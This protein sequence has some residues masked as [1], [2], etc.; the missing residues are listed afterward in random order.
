MPS[1]SF[2]I[3]CAE[4]LGQ[5]ATA[6]LVTRVDTGQLAEAA[7][8]AILEV[9]YCWCK[10]VDFSSLRSKRISPVRAGRGTALRTLPTFLRRFR[11]LELL[12]L[13]GL[14]A[15]VG[16]SA[17]KFKFCVTDVDI[18]WHLKTGDWIF[19]HA[20]FPHTGLFTWTAANHPWAA[21]S[22]G[23]EVLLSRAYAWF[24]LVG[25]G[26]YGTLL[27]IGVAYSVYWMARRLSGNFWIALPVT[28]LACAAFIFSLNPRPV[29]F[30]MM[31]FAVTLT[32]LL[33]ARRTGREKLLYWLPLVFMLWANLHIQFV[34]GLMALGIAVAVNIA[35]NLA[36]RLGWKPDWL[37]PARLPTFTLLIVSLASFFAT[38]IGPYSY[39]LY[40]VVL[41][42]VHAVVPYRILIEMQP[43][44]FRAGSHYVELL[45]I[46]FAFFAVGRQKRV[47]VFKLLLLCV[48]AVR[49]FHI[50]RDAWFVSIS[51][52]ACIAESLAGTLEREPAETWLEN[53]GVAALVAVLLVVFAGE[54]DFNPPGLERAMTEVLP[55]NAVNYL[56][57]H[58]APG[59]LYNTLDWGGYLIWKMPERPVSIDG[60]TD[61]YGDQLEEL[62][63]LTAA[64]AP[65]YLNDPYLNESGV[66]LL[67]KK[68]RLEGL[69]E[70]DPRFSLVY[71]DDI[72][73][74]F[75][76]R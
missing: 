75:F 71:Q 21:Y 43:M 14:L 25:I 35:Q 6:F 61:L 8:R 28:V 63:F 74:L 76:R 62:F 52:A 16:V 30:S 27:T 17:F 60:R 34:F 31:L 66:V 72:S 2:R 9:P 56:R 1:Q 23:Y 67:Q 51:A 20:A 53:L 15:A 11:W 58:P 40:D 45:W 29:F 42:Y 54:A 39:K 38:C 36:D 48:T 47:D 59:P 22:W 5:P 73:A 65:S 44:N 70:R 49:G 33:E 68:N 46:G 41:Q 13:T 32:L 18:G 19:Q 57:Q 69:L 50:M 26:V 12:T 64:G 4:Q 37:E 7:A 55:V 24:G 10:E 3:A